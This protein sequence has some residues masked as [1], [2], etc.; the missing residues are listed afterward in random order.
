MKYQGVVVWMSGSKGYGFIKPLSG[1]KDIFC[2]W[3]DILMEGFKVL[4]KDQKVEY[5]LGTTPKG[6]PKAIKI[7]V[8]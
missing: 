4:Y 2:Y 6:D 3:Q 5:E 8:I 1:G 7:K